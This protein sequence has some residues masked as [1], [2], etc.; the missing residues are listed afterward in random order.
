VDRGGEHPG[1]GNHLHLPVE[2]GLLKLTFW[3]AAGTVT[4]S[5]YL[6][7]TERARVLVDCGLF[8][9]LKELRLRNREPFPVPPPSLDAV[10]LTHAHLDHS[11][12]LPR[13]VREGFTGTVY[14]TRATR[15]LCGVLLPDSGHLQEEEAAYANRRGY[16]KHH[17]ALPLY[18]WRE[19]TEAMAHLRGLDWK[20]AHK[21]AAG[22]RVR[23]LPAGHLLGA[24]SVLMESGEGSILFSGDIGRPGDPLLPPAEGGAADALVV[25]STYGDRLHGSSDPRP[26]LAEVIRRT[27]ARGGV[28]L[29]PSFA[30]GR[31][32]L[33]LYHLHALREEGKIPPIPVFLDSPMAIEA[34]EIFRTHHADH[35]LSAAECARVCAGAEMVT[36][37]E[38]SK[39]LDRLTAP[40]IIISASGMAT[41]GRVLHHLKRYAPDPRATIL[42]A[43]HQ[44][45]GT[46]GDSLVKGA[47]SVKIH[48]GMVPVRATVAQLDMLSGHADRAELLDWMRALPAPPRETFVTHGEPRAAAA[49]QASIAEE[50]GWRARVPA[51]GEGFEI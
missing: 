26:E 41:G 9:G 8:Q 27:A 50:L 10:V 17:P 4:G 51:H 18:T 45:V 38:R 46:R 7:E 13:L 5:R 44:A 15:E 33:L 31:A 2:G 22:V 3:G 20:R 35:R 21:V 12:Y 16:S 34:S 47:E 11:G 28:L 43:G 32:Q 42:F 37:V 24:A 30:V 48:G 19:A 25:E 40:A 39:E 23:F 6:V 14:C 1:G 36:G 49:L 29:I